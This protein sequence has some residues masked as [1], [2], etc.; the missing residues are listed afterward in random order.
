MLTMCFALGCR[1]QT[2]DGLGI[3]ICHLSSQA[4][5]EQHL[6]EYTVMRIS[7][8]S[9]NDETGH[10]DGARL[11]WHSSAAAHADISNRLQAELNTTNQLVHRS[12]DG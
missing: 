3:S 2:R 4:I 7:L 11:G 6:V 9:K 10:P 1:V 8:S 12:L 5:A